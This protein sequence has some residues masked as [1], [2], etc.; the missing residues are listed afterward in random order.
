MF[1]AMLAIRI[2]PST[3]TEIVPP[4]MPADKTNLVLGWIVSA[5]P[6]VGVTIPF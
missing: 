6:R 2:V 4:L 5:I 3:A 1:L